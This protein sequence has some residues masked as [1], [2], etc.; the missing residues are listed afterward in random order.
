MGNELT[1]VIQGTDDLFE[2]LSTLLSAYSGW[3]VYKYSGSNIE[4]MFEVIPSL[5]S[6]FCVIAYGESDYRSHP[7]RRKA[8]FHVV[9]GATAPRRRFETGNLQAFALVDKVI[10]LV[11]QQILPG[12][13]A[14][15]ETDEDHALNV[16]TTHTVF[17]VEVTIRDS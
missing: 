13:R 2:G 17:D 3:T 10:E 15:I 12:T 5:R 8:R 11:E 9:V 6:P 16:S 14:L 4:V 7:N 1:G